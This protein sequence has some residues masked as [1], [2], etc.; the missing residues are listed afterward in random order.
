MHYPSDVLTGALIGAGS[1]VLIHSLRKE[2]FKFKNN[3]LG[4]KKNDDGSINGGAI[5]IF[6]AGFLA[7]VAID[8][9]LPKTTTT[10]KL[11]I[12]AS[13]FHNNNLGIGFNINYK[14]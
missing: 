12:N 5:S 7:S 6:A 2:F 10:N 8:L 9:I 3:L 11:T 4:E 13:P 1:S 14:F